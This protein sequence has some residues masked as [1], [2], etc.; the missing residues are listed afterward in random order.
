MRLNY[1]CLIRRMTEYLLL[2]EPK[3]NRKPMIISVR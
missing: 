1:H 2:P 3:T